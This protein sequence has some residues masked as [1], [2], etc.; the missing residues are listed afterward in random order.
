MFD[1]SGR[2]TAVTL[3]EVEPNIVTAIKTNERDGYE[4]VQIGTAKRRDGT[5]RW[6]REIRN[7]THDLKVGDTLNVSVF[8]KGDAV[9]IIGYSKGKGFQG[10]VKRHGFGGAPK[11]HGTKHAHRE[12][13]SI[14]ATQPQRVIKGRKMAGRMGGDRV[15][16][17]NLRIFAVDA[18]RNQLAI[19]G[20][21]PGS[22][23]SLIIVKG[24]KE[25]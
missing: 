10:V 13:G 11:T 20:A 1:E 21:V 25:S 5:F 15:T 22:R 3:L 18:E 12:P 14:G 6:R 19:A 23:G 7:V 16:I 9:D 2:V 4:A 24:R 8:E 17:K